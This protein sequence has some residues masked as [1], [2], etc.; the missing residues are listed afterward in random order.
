MRASDRWWDRW[1]TR[2]L[3]EALVRARANVVRAWDLD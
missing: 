2:H 1:P 3:A